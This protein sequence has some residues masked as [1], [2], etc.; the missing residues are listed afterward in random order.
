MRQTSVAILI[1]AM[2]LTL[3]PAA[4]ADGTGDLYKA[5][6]QMCHGPDGKG[7]PTGTKMG[8]RDFHSPEIMKLTEAQIIDAITKGKN[9]MPA[10]ATKLTAEQIKALA[11]YVKELGKK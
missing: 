4:L 6:C 7:T 8:A 1:T 9:K 11:G 3:A 5:K 10:Y 2:I